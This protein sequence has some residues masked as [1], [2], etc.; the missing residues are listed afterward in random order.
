M[1]VRARGPARQ[2]RSPATR[3]TVGVPQGLNRVKA[4]GGRALSGDV[5]A[6]MESRFGAS[7]AD[8]RIHSGQEPS[9]LAKSVGARAFTSGNDLV[10]GPG[11][12]RPHEP[13]GQRL[14][15]HELTHVVQ[16]REGR[17]GVPS[18]LLQRQAEPNASQACDPDNPEGFPLI[19][20][21]QGSS[22]RSPRDAVGFAQQ[23]LNLFFQNIDDEIANNPNSRAKQF[24][25]QQIAGMTPPSDAEQA[26]DA[27]D[28]DCKFGPNT[29][30]A[31]KAFQAA[32]FPLEPSEWDGKIGA[33]TWSLL[34][35]MGLQRPARTSPGSG[36]TARP[37]LAAGSVT[38][39]IT[40][41]EA[42]SGSDVLELSD[43]AERLIDFDYCGL[44]GCRPFA[45]DFFDNPLAASYV[46]FLAAHNRALRTPA[47]IAQLAILSQLQLN[48]PDIL[49]HLPRRKEFYEIKPDSPSG[50]SDGRIKLLA[51]NAFYGTFRL[52]YVEGSAY[53]PTPT[54]LIG[55]RGGITVTLEARRL[56]TGL[57]VYS[58]CFTGP[59]ALLTAAAIA[60][61][62]AILLVLIAS[63]G[64]ARIPVLA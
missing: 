45:T 30:R 9:L 16:Q 56:R 18:G 31:T 39:C 40:P 63:R 49:T 50:R 36:G 34:D 64:R 28:V 37:I 22:G 1:P 57:I 17:A 55:S 7:F 27:L 8:V 46:A 2:S 11:E 4:S 61:I 12:F 5:R 44:V 3:A 6:H 58:I 43:F 35:L 38:K 41:G 53:I 14:L 52:P 23:K 51:L 29:T 20:D 48:R 10:F 32:R 15:A 26:G 59:A 47:T 21:R 60:A 24:M 19:F 33:K 62:I 25:S 13:D 42:L 54:I